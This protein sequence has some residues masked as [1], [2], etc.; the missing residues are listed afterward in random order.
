[1][2]KRIRHSALWLHAE[3]VLVFSQFV[4]VRNELAARCKYVR[5]KKCKFNDALQ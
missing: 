1:V 4:P 2:L 3:I 5:F